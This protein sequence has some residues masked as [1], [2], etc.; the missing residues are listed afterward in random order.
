MENKSGHPNGPLKEKGALFA[1]DPGKK[2]K[3]KKKKRKGGEKGPL[4][5]FGGESHDPGPVKNNKTAVHGDS[6]L[7]WIKKRH[8]L[9]TR[10]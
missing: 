7:A 4:P 1:L 2:K 6:A 8:D 10:I 3:K 9:L 5:I